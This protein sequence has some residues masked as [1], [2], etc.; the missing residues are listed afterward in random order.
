MTARREW[1]AN[2]VSWRV[3][4]HSGALQATWWP[5]DAY[6]VTRTFYGYTRRDAARIVA[7]ERRAD[8]ARREP[9]AG[10]IVR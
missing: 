2:G 5:N 7:D 8:N 10:V 9:V 4:S 6:I 3:V 1:Y